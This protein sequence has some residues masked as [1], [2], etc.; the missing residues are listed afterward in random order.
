MQIRILG[1][2]GGVGGNLRTTSFLVDD[3]VLI[4][5][6][7]GLNDLP[8][9]QMSG[10]RHIFITHSHMDHIT[11]LPLLADS[12]FG[13][14]AEPIVVHA[15]EKT[16]K[17]LKAHIFN[18]VIWPDFSELPSK[19]NPCIRFDVMR[20][21]EKIAIRQRQ[22]EMIPVNHTV[23]GVGYCVSG[24]K[25]TVVF[26]GDTTTNDTLWSRLNEYDSID[27]LFVEAAFANHDL[28]ISRISKH[29]CP[30]LLAEDLKKL[31]H[32]PEIWM[33]HFK[34][35]DEDLIFQQCQ[36][37][38]SDFSVNRLIGGEVFKI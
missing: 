38:I 14:H 4:D 22:I 26:S 16:I 7:T 12:M 36:D 1:W 29:Y 19:D 34:P 32:R 13:V 21:G 5:A 9:N 20:P 27:L 2:S 23:P 18:W 15:Q 35:G 10:I 33:T 24:P 17:A 11:S 3:D 31:K 30:Q 25:G 37:A 28:E 6:G 8:L